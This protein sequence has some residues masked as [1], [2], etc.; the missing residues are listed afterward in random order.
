MPRIA[1][2]IQQA[3]ENKSGTVTL[4]EKPGK[5]VYTWFA[6]S[7]RYFIDF[8]DDYHQHGLIQ[9]QRPTTKSQIIVGA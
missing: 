5:K 1:A 7:E 6:D 3:T 4:E 2:L 8:A 9:C